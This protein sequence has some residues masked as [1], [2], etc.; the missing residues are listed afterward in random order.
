M[1]EKEKKWWVVW[2]NQLCWL[3]AGE[4]AAT[5]EVITGIVNDDDDGSMM[6]IKEEPLS[7][8]ESNSTETSQSRTSGTTKK[9]RMGERELRIEVKEEAT[10]EKPR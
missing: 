3:D 1:D 4:V 6:S 10:V 5:E 7:D 9:R 2:H 8:T